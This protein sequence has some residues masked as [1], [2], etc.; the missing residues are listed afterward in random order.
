VFDVD[1]V[2]KHVLVVDDNA[3]VALYTAMSLE[4]LHVAHR[5]EIAVSGMDAL[6]KVSAEHFD[7]VISD[8]RMPGMDGL[9]LFQRIQANCPNIQFILMTGDHD[10]EVEATANQQGIRHLITK[11][12]TIEQLITVVRSLSDKS[13]KVAG[14]KHGN[15]SE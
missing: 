8:L 9:M 3:S 2:F 14:Q 10:T 12:F 1:S 4:M 15:G 11:P 13:G 7:L 6:E 5:V